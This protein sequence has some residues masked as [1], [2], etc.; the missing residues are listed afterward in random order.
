MSQQQEQEQPHLILCYRKNF[1][2]QNFIR[3]KQKFYTNFF[4]TPIFLTAIF[5]NP[6]F[7]EPKI[8]GHQIFGE[9]KFFE[10]HNFFGP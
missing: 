6:N 10:T 3:A 2:T 8:L 4:G 7:F 1:W 5:W 9:P